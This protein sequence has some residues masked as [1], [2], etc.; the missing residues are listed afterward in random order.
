MAD[1]V[2]DLMFTLRVSEEAAKRL[3]EIARQR[4]FLTVDEYMQA[5]VEADS[6]DVYYETSDEEIVEGLREGLR[7][8]QEGNV[9]P[10][11]QLWD[12]LDDDE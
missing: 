8:A 9:Y 5:V 3:E 11:S 6:F 12:D 10:I 4:G 2:V 1:K 7:D